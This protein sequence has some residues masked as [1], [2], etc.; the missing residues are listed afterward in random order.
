MFSQTDHFQPYKQVY[1]FNNGLGIYEPAGEWWS[2][3]YSVRLGECI[4]C[5]LIQLDSYFNTF[6]IENTVRRFV[7]KF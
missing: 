3:R 1:Y 5:I 2:R 7:G 6:E 4:F